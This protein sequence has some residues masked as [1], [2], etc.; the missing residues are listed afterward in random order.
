MFYPVDFVSLYNEYTSVWALDV[1]HR[2]MAC[3]QAQV[4]QLDIVHRPILSPRVFFW[5]VQQ[6]NQ[7]SK[8]LFKVDETTNWLI[9]SQSVQVGPLVNNLMSGYVLEPSDT[10]S[11]YTWN[12]E[13]MKYTHVQCYSKLLSRQCCKLQLTTLQL[14]SGSVDLKFSGD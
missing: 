2:H 7:P 14:A 3:V 11:G 10:S 13:V 1:M 12:R 6:S 4:Y 9:I 5:E 8:V